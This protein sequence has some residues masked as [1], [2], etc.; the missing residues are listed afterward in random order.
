MHPIQSQLEQT[1]R[2]FLATSASGLGGVALASMLAE[3]GLL[4]KEFANPLAPR[5]PHFEPQAKACINIFM[6]GAP[7]HLDLFDPK[8]ELNKRDGQSLPKEVLDKARFA[9]IKPDTCLLY[10]SDAADE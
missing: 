4:A 8:P 10:T 3:D 6:A 2:N 9:F 1:R 5:K 7:S